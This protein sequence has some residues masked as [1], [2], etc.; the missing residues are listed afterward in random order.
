MAKDNTQNDGKQTTPVDAKQL[1]PAD[2][3][4]P[5]SVVDQDKEL[6]PVQAPEDE[7]AVTD[8]EPM[9]KDMVLMAANDMHDCMDKFIV[10]AETHAA[11]A[12]KEADAEASL[13]FHKLSMV[14]AEFRNGLKVAVGK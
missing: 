13:I 11:T 7:T 10:A 12:L 6:P 14:F 1:P 5:E 9:S 4:P 8:Q 3:K 2:T